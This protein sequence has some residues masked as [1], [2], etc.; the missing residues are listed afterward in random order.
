MHAAEPFRTT[1]GL[2]LTHE[3]PGNYSLVDRSDQTLV[4]GNFRAALEKMPIDGP[5]NTEDRQRSAHTW[6]IFMD[7][8][9]RGSELLTSTPPRIGHLFGETWGRRCPHPLN[10]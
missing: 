2:P 1:T 3:V 10:R 9:I 4:Q 6:A 8:R 7:A 5:G